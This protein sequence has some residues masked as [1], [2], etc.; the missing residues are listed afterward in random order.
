MTEVIKEGWLSKLGGIRK[1]WKKRW[2][3][4]YKDALVRCTRT[5]TCTLVCSTDCTQSDIITFL[6]HRYYFYIL[7]FSSRLP[8]NTPNCTDVAASCINPMAT[9]EPKTFPLLADDVCKTHYADGDVK[10]CKSNTA[11][12]SLF[13]SYKR[14]FGQCGV[15]IQQLEQMECALAC[16]PSQSRFCSND[17]L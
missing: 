15:C 8:P 16:D 5:R 2:F 6:V 9:F 12:K 14:Q 4:A 7:A 11:L 17:T 10:C 1:N 3:V 13:R